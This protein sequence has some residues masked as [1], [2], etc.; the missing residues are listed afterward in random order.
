MN[1]RWLASFG[2]ELG[3]QRALGP[4]DDLVGLAL[5]VV[6]GALQLANPGER[7]LWFLEQRDEVAKGLEA[8]LT[9]DDQLFGLC[10]QRIQ[11]WF[12]GVDVGG[13]VAHAIDD[14]VDFVGEAH[15]VGDVEA[16]DE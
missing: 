14:V 12:V 6:D 16:H 15:G 1:S 4:V 10:P 11:V 7:H 5:C 13:R 3:N 9:G 8:A 2:R